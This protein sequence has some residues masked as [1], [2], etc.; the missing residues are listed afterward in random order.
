NALEAPGNSFHDKQD[1]QDDEQN[2]E[3][4]A[5]AISPIAAVR[6]GGQAADQQQNQDNQQDRPH[7]QTLF[8]D[9]PSTGR[10]TSPGAHEAG[11]SAEIVSFLRWA[12]GVALS[13]SSSLAGGAAG[14]A[15]F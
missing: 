7:V 13:A 5:G 8:K 4:A 2:A 6:P 3:D 1:K 12:G 15:G 11:R 9:E 10:G 14:V